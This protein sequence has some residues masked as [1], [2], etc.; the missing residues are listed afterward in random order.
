MYRNWIRVACI[1][2]TLV[3]CP[4][5]AEEKTPTDRLQTQERVETVKSLQ[6]FMY[7]IW[8][9]DTSVQDKLLRSRFLNA[10]LKFSDAQ[11]L[12][13]DE[14][15][16][17]G[18]AESDVETGKDWWT[19]TSTVRHCVDYDAGTKHC[20]TYLDTRLVVNVWTNSEMEEW[21]KKRDEYMSYAHDTIDDASLTLDLSGN[22]F[23]AQL[24]MT[25]NCD[26]ADFE[27]CKPSERTLTL[28]ITMHSINPTE[29][30]VKKSD[31]SFL[32]GTMRAQIDFLMEATSKWVKHYMSKGRKP[33]LIFS[34]N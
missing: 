12:R 4:L 2:S 14:R 8:N 32:R 33:D 23:A 26:D 25:S 34:K 6:A 13:H 15:A 9:L 28:T 29:L 7:Q 21:V 11:R 10:S 1:A 30:R 20:H 16:G 27:G 19:L 17:G 5:K 22:I 18:I 24:K 31:D 3:V